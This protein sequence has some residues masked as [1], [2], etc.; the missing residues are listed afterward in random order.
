MELEYITGDSKYEEPLVKC[1]AC[2]GVASANWVSV[3]QDPYEVQ[4]EPFHCKCGWTQE[5]PHEC[6]GP[7][8]IS[9]SKCNSSVKEAVDHER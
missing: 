5:C 7:K 3:Y 8:C 1:P 9:F 2:G 4:V 6:I